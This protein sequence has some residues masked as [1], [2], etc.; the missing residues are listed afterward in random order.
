MGVFMQDCAGQ[1]II[2]D[3][4]IGTVVLTKMIL[5]RSTGMVDCNLVENGIA[6]H[7][8]SPEK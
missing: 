8:E 2:V 6:T 1:R 3:N 4:M 5:H 7:T